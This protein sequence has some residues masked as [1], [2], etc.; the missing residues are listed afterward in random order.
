VTKQS[1][2]ADPDRAA[3]IALHERLLADG[4]KR[5]LDFVM[6]TRPERMSTRW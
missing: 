1:Q 5:T 6:S 2:S 4:I 3:E